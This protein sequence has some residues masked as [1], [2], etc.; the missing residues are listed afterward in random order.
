MPQQMMW[1]QIESTYR[2]QATDGTIVV[3]DEE[4]MSLALKKA[5]KSVFETDW[6]IETL[7]VTLEHWGIY[8]KHWKDV[9]TQMPR[10]HFTLDPSQKGGTKAPRPSTQSGPLRSRLMSGPLPTKRVPEE[11]EKK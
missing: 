11:E 7:T 1:D 3:V 8:A 10:A 5:G 6:W 9:A 4:A 2:G